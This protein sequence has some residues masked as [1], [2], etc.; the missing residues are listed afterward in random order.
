MVE[1]VKKVGIIIIFVGVELGVDLIELF[2][3]V[4]YEEYVFW[5]ILFIDFEMIK[6][7]LESIIC[8]IIMFVFFS[9]ILI[10]IIRFFFFYLLIL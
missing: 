9:F 6:Y 7:L 5:V 1:E 2:V 8:K 10:I 4:F 3:I